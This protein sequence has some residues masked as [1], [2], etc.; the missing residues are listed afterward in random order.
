MKKLLKNENVQA[1]LIIAGVFILTGLIAMYFLLA[2][3]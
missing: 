1:T 2:D 3:K